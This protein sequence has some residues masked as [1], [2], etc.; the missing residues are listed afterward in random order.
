MMRACL[1]CAA[2]AAEPSSD[3]EAGVQAFAEGR[4]E[5][6]ARIL[7]RAYAAEPE[8]ALLFAWAQAERY[9]GRCDVAV[10]LYRGYLE[11]EPPADVRALAREAIEACGEDPDHAGEPEPEPEPEPVVEPKPEPEPEPEITRHFAPPRR[12]T[13]AR[14]PWGHALTWPGL[15]VAGVG[16]GLLGEAHRRQAAGDAALD[17]QAYRDAL[18][19][20]PGLSRAGIGLLVGGGAVLVAG[21]IRFVVVAVQRRDDDEGAG[22]PAAASA[23]PWRPRIG[24]G[25]LAWQFELAPRDGRALR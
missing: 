25:S 17:E 4:Y 7:E 13:A 14:D 2:L 18:H 21:V 23:P 6:A 15:A 22:A 12:R 20:A 5:D 1:L 19:G 8:P 16:A 24:V 9:A 3:A 11:G 10:P